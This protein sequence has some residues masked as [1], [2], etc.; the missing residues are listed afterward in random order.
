MHAQQLKRIMGFP[1]EQVADNVADV[2]P[3]TLPHR[4]SLLNCMLYYSGSF[5]SVQ[6]SFSYVWMTPEQ[7]AAKDSARGFHG[8]G[9]NGGLSGLVEIIAGM[10]VGSVHLGVVETWLHA[11][12]LKSIVRFH[13]EQVHG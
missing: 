8:I 4:S 3:H 12:K 10:E 11:Q 6:Q 1:Y 13:Y 7:I 2:L 9:W 5:K